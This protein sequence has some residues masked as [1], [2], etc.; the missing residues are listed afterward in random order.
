MRNLPKSIL[1]VFIIFAMPISGLA[2]DWTAIVDNKD[3]F[4]SYKIEN[5]NVIFVLETVSDFTDEISRKFPKSDFFSIEVD[6]NQNGKIDKN[7][8]V[9]YAITSKSIAIC[10]NYLIDYESSTYCGT[11]KSKAYLEIS[12]RGTN[13]EQR[14]H[15]VFK[16]TIPKSEL[17]LSG[18]TAHAVFKC[19]TAKKGYTSYPK[20]DFDDDGGLSSFSKVIKV[21]L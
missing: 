9:N 7:L 8:D 16:F 21:Q 19:H 18:D 4:I 3:H 2:D 14:E 17:N 13:K 11:F 5:Q 1:F 6:V 15:P 20:L 12:F 10:T